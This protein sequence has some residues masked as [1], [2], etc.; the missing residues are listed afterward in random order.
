MLD[1]ILEPRESQGKYLP[2]EGAGEEFG[3]M[4]D[5]LVEVLMRGLTTRSG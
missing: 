3:Q 2:Q 5:Y 4:G 1:E